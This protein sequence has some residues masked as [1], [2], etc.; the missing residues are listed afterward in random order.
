MK[1]RSDLFFPNWALSIAVLLAIGAALVWFGYDEHRQTIEREFRALE[2][3]NR[4]AEA[5]VTSL[6]HNVEMLLHGIAREQKTL[7][8]ARRA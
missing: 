5:Q 4:I 7:T 8:P 1:N 3:N 6:L 2:S